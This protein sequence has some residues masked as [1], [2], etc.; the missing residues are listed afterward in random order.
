MTMIDQKQTS[1]MRAVIYARVST[2]EQAKHNYSLESQVEM[3]RKWKVKIL[4]HAL[5][6][7]DIK[8]D[9]AI[10]LHIHR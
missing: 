10:F 5:E 4:N 7:K 2:E 9:I 3:A 8:K 6:V 1:K